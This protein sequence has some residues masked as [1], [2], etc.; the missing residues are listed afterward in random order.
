MFTNI[1]ATIELVL[2]LIGLY[3][4]FM[5]YSDKKR[6]AEREKRAQDRDDAIDK[7]QN[8]KDEDEFD[9]AQEEINRNHPAP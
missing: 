6:A 8:A 2:K 7:Q 1:F 9:K 3:D 5:D 4:Q